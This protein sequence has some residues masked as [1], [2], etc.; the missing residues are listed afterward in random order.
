L[1]PVNILLFNATPDAIINLTI[2]YKLIFIFLKQVFK[3]FDFVS[4]Y[5]EC[6]DDKF[7]YY[8]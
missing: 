8:R 5:T 4:L 2:S 7:G 1:F 6:I 3:D